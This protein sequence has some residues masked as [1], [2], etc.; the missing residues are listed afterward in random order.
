MPKKKKV[1]NEEELSSDDSFGLNMLFSE[2]CPPTTFISV[3]TKSA[4]K[5]NKISPDNTINPDMY[6]KEVV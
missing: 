1:E 3:V 2:S 4:Q 6:I 5:M